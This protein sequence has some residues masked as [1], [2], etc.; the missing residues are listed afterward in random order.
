M[1]KLNYA[2]EIGVGSR[3]PVVPRPL[4]ILLLVLLAIGVGC[5]VRANSPKSHAHSPHSAAGPR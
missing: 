1:Y 5:L 3:E 4:A 2:E